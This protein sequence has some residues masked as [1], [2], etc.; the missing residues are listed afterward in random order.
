MG[1][2]P[3]GGTSSITISLRQLL[4]FPQ[5]SEV[6]TVVAM[7]GDRGK[8]NHI[9][10]RLMNGESALALD[11]QTLLVTTAKFPDLS[12]FWFSCLWDPK[13]KMWQRGQAGF[14]GR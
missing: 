5:G 8:P 9:L 2:R 13:N 7:D 14:F 11:S 6:L 1:Q 12:E 10:Y 3:G 4:L